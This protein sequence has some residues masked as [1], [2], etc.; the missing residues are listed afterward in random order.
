[1]I[2]SV[3]GYDIY[4]PFLEEGLLNKPYSHWQMHAVSLFLR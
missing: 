3:V 4:L 1:M 2:C